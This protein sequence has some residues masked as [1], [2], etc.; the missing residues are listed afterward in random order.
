MMLSGLLL[1]TGA[2][3]A[4]VGGIM[5]LIEAFRESFL[6]GIG[7]LLLWPVQL[8]FVATHWAQTKKG[9]LMALAGVGLIILGAVAA[10]N[11]AAQTDVSVV[12]PAQTATHATFDQVTATI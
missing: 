2:I 9:F 5:V 3:I 12:T 6:W 1:A 11:K 7:S 10:P 8:Y 4:I